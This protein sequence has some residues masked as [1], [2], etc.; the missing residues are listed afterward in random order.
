MKMAK[1]T[2]QLRPHASDPAIVEI[3]VPVAANKS[4]GRFPSAR[5]DRNRRCYAMHADDTE[6]FMVF[7]HFYNLHVVNA[8]VLTDPWIPAGY[9]PAHD[10][11]TGPAR[12]RT[13]TAEQLEINRRGIAK[14]R[15]ALAAAR[16]SHEPPSSAPKR[17]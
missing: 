12:N 4:M 2:V 9:S 3:V 5:F 17:A 1:I 10:T 16:E 8:P 11:D 6:A 7:A 15:A 14:V 13:I